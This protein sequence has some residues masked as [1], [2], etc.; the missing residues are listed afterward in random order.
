MQELQCAKG[1]LMI[2]MGAKA[3]YVQVCDGQRL[4]LCWC[5]QWLMLCD[6]MPLMFGMDNALLER[7]GASHGDWLAG[8]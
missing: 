8:F 1:M 3:L 6:P 2:V 5:F 7:I 4:Y